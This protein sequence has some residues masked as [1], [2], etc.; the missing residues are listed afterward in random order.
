MRG[1]ETCAGTGSRHGSGQVGGPLAVEG[2]AV[3]GVT[4]EEVSVAGAS[5]DAVT[6]HTESAQMSAKETAM[7]RRGK[8][9]VLFFIFVPFVVIEIKKR[10]AFYLFG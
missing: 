2:V 9:L 8:N 4:V 3:E 6:E 1:A 5:A 7:P 10:L